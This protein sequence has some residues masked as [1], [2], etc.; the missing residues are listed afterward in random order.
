MLTKRQIE[1]KLLRLQIKI[2]DDLEEDGNIRAE[3]MGRNFLTVGHPEN[4]IQVA[5]TYNSNEKDF[6]FVVTVMKGEKKEIVATLSGEKNLYT[7]TDVIRKFVNI[8]NIDKNYT[9]F[10][11]GV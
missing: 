10:L 5:T 9:G 3:H 6:E 4:R 1:N 7:A 11:K 8:Y 2:I